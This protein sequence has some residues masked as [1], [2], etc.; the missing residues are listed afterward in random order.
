[1]F[2]VGA[3]IEGAGG[4]SIGMTLQGVNLLNLTTVGQTDILDAEVVLC[5]VRVGSELSPMR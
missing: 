2:V 1:M 5:I 3:I 4:K